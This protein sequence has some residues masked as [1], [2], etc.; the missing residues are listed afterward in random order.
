MNATTLINNSDP[1]PVRKVGNFLNDG[2]FVFVGDHAGTAIPARLGDLGLSAHDRGR[3]IAVDLGVETLGRHLA[4]IFS[5]PFVWQAYSRLV[6]DCNR[7]PGTEGWVA[8]VSDGSAIPGN[9]DLDRDALAQRK[10]EVFDPYHEAIADLLN[11]R[12]ATGLQTVF[13]SLHSFTPIMNGNAR[14]WEIGILHDGAQD[15]FSLDLLELLGRGPW[16]VGDNE[17]YH[18]DDTDFTVPHHAFARGLSYAEI[19]VRQDV[20]AEQPEKIADTL[21][22]AFREAATREGYC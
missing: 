19:E 6:V 22:Q 11:Q 16:V 4:D 2:L 21:A 8:P 9:A 14:P 15:A 1:H 3:H 5:A 7:H 20:L 10:E 13:I 12:A 17:P 18:M